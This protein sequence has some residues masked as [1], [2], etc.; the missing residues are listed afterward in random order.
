MPP[1]S[2]GLIFATIMNTPSDSSSDTSSG[3]P[4]PQTPAPVPETTKAAPAGAKASGPKR[5]IIRQWPKT[6]VLYPMA[7]VALICAIVGVIAGPGMTDAPAV[8]EAKPTAVEK[9]EAPS[10]EDATL[11]AEGAEDPVKE[12]SAAE[13]KKDA[14]AAVGGPWRKVDRTMAVI[15]LFVLTF[16]LFSLCVD[17]EVRWAFVVFA[18]IVILILGAVLADIFFGFFTGFFA[19]LG[20]F[21][22]VA[23]PHFYFALTGIWIFLMLISLL[24]VRFNFVKIESNELVVVRGFLERQ[25]RHSTFRMRYTKDIQDVF[26]YYL[27][28][29]RSGR[30]VF[31]FPGEEEPVVIDNVIQI[32]RVIKDLDEVSSVMQVK[33]NDS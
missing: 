1:V 12:A 20:G 8:E 25:Q 22:P 31:N 15:F 27:P 29:V 32:D 4:A 13:S 33:T 26:E 11:P 23:N 17:F 16:S 3:A 14:K 9:A 21:T 6:P 5:I 10:G 30:L 2:G 19:F 28:F 7:L 18:V 24:I